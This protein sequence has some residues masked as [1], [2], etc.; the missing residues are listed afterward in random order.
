MEEDWH[1]DTKAALRHK[2]KEPAHAQRDLAPGAIFWGD[3]VT[4]ATVILGRQ[5]AR[6]AFLTSFPDNQ[7]KKKTQ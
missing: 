3:V 1:A 2:R 4:L 6:T 5:R 7:D